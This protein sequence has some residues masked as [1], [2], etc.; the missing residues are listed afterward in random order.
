MVDERME[1]AEDAWAGKCGKWIKER[2]LELYCMLTQ[3]T[4][5]EVFEVFVY[6]MEIVSL[7]V[8]VPVSKYVHLFSMSIWHSFYIHAFLNQIH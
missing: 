6:C 1:S 5:A 2:H 8:C 3:H 7:L 4:Q